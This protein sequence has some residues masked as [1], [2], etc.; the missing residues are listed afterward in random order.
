MVKR[1]CDLRLNIEPSDESIINPKRKICLNISEGFRGVSNIQVVAD[2]I[3]M[4][5][6]KQVRF[7]QSLD[8]QTT[9]RQKAH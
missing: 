2:R 9:N 5:L 1:P 4:Y 7:V 8:Q 6:S 3:Y